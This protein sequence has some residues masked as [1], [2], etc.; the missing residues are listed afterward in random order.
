MLEKRRIEL[1]YV[2]SCL[3]LYNK[4]RAAEKA[5]LVYINLIFR[6]ED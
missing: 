4:T 3:I 2:V 1:F 6:R 5:A